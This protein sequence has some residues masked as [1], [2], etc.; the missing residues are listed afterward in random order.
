MDHVH[1]RAVFLQRTHVLVDILGV[2]QMPLHANAVDQPVP[3]D[4][5][6]PVRRNDVAL[7]LRVV[8]VPLVLCQ[9]FH[10][11]VASVL[12]PF[13]VVIVKKLRHDL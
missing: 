10:D 13:V 11:L 3:V 5:A 2:A 8:L 6:V 4:R 12:K 9:E 1:S 7:H